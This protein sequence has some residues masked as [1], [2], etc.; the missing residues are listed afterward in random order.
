[1]IRTRSQLAVVV[2]TIAFFAMYFDEHETQSKYDAVCTVEDSQSVVINGRTYTNATYSIEPVNDM[3]PC[4]SVSTSS[5][6]M[7]TAGDAMNCTTDGRKI[8]SHRHL[9]RGTEREQYAIIAA[10][11]FAAMTILSLYIVQ[12]FQFVHSC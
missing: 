8:L 5:H 6:H 4:I 9:Y 11:M 1:M 10:S 7:H 2:F 12:F 3:T